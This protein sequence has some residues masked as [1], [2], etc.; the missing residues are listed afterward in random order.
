MLLVLFL[1]RFFLA[2]PVHRQFRLHRWIEYEFANQSLG[3]LHLFSAHDW[4]N[5]LDNFEQILYLFVYFH[6]KM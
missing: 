3:L 1:I 2:V 6:L 5:Q 4:H